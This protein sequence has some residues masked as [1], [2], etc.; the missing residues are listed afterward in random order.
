MDEGNAPM[1]EEELSRLRTRSRGPAVV[2]REEPVSRTE[3]MKDQAR[4]PVP[5]LKRTVPTI[6]EHEPSGGEASSEYDAGVETAIPRYDAGVETAMPRYD[7]GVAA[8]YT[9]MVAMMREVGDLLA[10]QRQTNI[11]AFDNDDVHAF[12]AG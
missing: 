5:E 8:A 11:H 2:I 7:T 12:D 9:Y 6:D 10:E 3:P 1:V 4:A